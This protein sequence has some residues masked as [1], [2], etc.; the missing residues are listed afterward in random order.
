MHARVQISIC[1]SARSYNHPRGVGVLVMGRWHQERIMRPRV[2]NRAGKEEKSIVPWAR[3]GDA[4]MI[5]SRRKR[6]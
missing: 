4:K 2:T 5:G 1:M 3:K 6:K